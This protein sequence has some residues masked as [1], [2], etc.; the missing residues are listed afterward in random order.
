MESSYRKTVL[1]NGVR[2]ITE[3]IPMFRSVAVGIWLEVGSR[4]EEESEQ[5]V[6]HLLEHMVFKGTDTRSA[7]QIAKEFDTIGGNSNAYTAKEHTCFHAKVLDTHLEHVVG[8]LLDI[9]MRSRFDPEDLELEKAVV[10]QEINMIEDSPEDYVHVLFGEAFWEGNPLGRSI[11]GSRRHIERMNRHGIL[12]YVRKSY[13]PSRIIVSA[14]GNVEHEGLLDLLDKELSSFHDTSF[15]NKRTS[16]ENSKKETFVYKDIEQV[17]VCLGTPGP[18]ATSQSRFADTLLNIILGGN[19]SSRLFQEIREKRGLAYTVYSYLNFYED[20]GMLGVYIG[21]GP[22]SLD[23]TLELTA[24][25]FAR[26]RSGDLTEDDL[27]SSKNYLK[28]SILLNAENVENRMMR[29]AKNEISFR[30]FISYQEI[31]RRIDAVTLDGLIELAGRRL[32]PTK[33]SLVT[34]GPVDRISVFPS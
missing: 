14:A 19:M 12:D 16:P 6:T 20:A 31:E 4:D 26:L 27:E 30:R 8:L 10:L 9:F 28:G 33:V 15:R 29:L 7:F 21:V 2:V 22:E 17:H 32:D 5:G 23:E 3:K 11:L 1:E 25:E 34:L 13:A 18:S 24:R